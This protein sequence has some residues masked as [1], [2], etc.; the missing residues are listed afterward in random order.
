M[1]NIRNINPDDFFTLSSPKEKTKFLLRYAI[2]APSTHNTQPWLFR[3]IKSGCEVYYDPKLL[4]PEG[5]PQKRDLHISIGCAIENIIVAA[6]YFGVFDYISMKSTTDSNHLATIYFKNLS[7]KVNDNYRKILNTIPKRVNARGIFQPI[8]VPVEILNEIS[9]IINN[10]YQLNN[11][12]VHWISNETQISE[13]ARLTAEG[14]KIAYAK[15]SFRKEMA[16]WLRSSLTRRKDGIPGYALKMPFPFSFIFPTLVRWFNLGFFLSKLNQMSLNSAPLVVI[17][18][19]NANNPLIW[20]NVGRIAQRIM[21]EFNARGWQTSIFVASI[22]MGK[23]YQR[24]QK[25]INTKQIPQFLFAVGK[26][27]STHKTTPRHPLEQKI[28]K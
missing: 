1:N 16:R 20:L 18:T 28:I 8:K 19:A 7:S 13:I 15:K 10:E 12:T 14:L 25:I 5:D 27:G 24:L 26:T 22:E 2:L 4:L 3:I 23:L 6:K 21:L 17:I 11:I 9:T